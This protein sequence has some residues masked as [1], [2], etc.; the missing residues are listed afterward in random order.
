MARSMSKQSLN[1]P[2]H[3]FSS[4]RHIC[5][6]TAAIHPQCHA[7]AEDETDE[8]ASVSIS[9]DL[10]P[11]ELFFAD[12]FHSI[13]KDHHRKNPDLLLNPSTPLS[14]NVAFPALCSDF[15]GISPVESL[16]PSIT[17]QVIERCGAPRH[18][19]PFIQTV[20]FFNWAM[21]SPSSHVDIFN[22][23]ID[24]SG[25]VRQFD[26][27]WHFINLM[28]S[29]NM[30]IPIETFSILIRRY[31]RAGLAAEA[32]HSFNRMDEYGCKP[33]KKAFSI[34][35]G[36]LGR[37][38]RA[39]EAQAFFDS[40]KDKFDL[41]AVVY[42]S[43]V[44][45]W[46]RANNISE[47]E[48]VFREMKTVGVQPDVY[49]YSIVIDT[50][51]RSGQ[52]TGA[53]DIF[54]EMLD[55]G[56]EPNAV[57]FNNLMRVHVKASRTEKVLQVYNQ[58]R[59]LLCEPDVITYNFLIDVH[60]KDK[61]REEA[62]KVLNSMVKKGCETNASTFNP[63][64]RC[65]AKAQDV[66]AAH[67]LFVKMKELKSKPNTVTYNILMKM[68]A[69][70]KSTDMVIKHWK[71]MEENEVEPNVNT[72][73]ILISMYCS[74]GHWNN[75]YKYL[76]EMIE[77]KCFRPSQQLY[78]MVMKQLIKAGQLK[79]HEELVQKMMDRGFVS[80]PLL[81]EPR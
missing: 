52:I 34:V 26:F 32:V 65:I 38:R 66:N 3:L 41:D 51:C 40:L 5:S 60:C 71:E 27:A 59:K 49:T 9:A 31:I 36:M 45:G 62:I 7:M 10:S 80:R 1:V 2:I 23:M 25:K 30:P 20:A 22:K 55:V 37:K 75:A 54:A 53:H 72:F 81:N 74:M 63:I 14:P 64:F 77:D 43:L 24:L 79:K 4:L 33:D 48:R 56:C 70:S 67:R 69:D 18:G 42:N 29:K 15:S 44:H 61:N 11:A 16:S 8:G 28:K 58:M 57:T 50:M 12:K 13:I 47:A 76:K 6:S 17:R 73:K 46:C 39:A 68:F 21:L 35:I 78:E 19:I